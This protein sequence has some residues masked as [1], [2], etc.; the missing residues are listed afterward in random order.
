MSFHRGT[1][2]RQLKTIFMT[3][4]PISLLLVL[5]LVV[6]WPAIVA[7][8]EPAKP[9]RQ[10]E[11]DPAHV[12][13][14]Q[15]GLRLFKTQVRQVLID[16]CVDCHGGSET[17]SGFDLATR[18]GL[19]RGG[20]HGPAIVPGKSADSNV[21]RFISRREK[22]FMPDGAEK[23][24][25]GQI[26]AIAHWIDLGA[27]YDK[28]LVDNPRDPDSWVNTVVPDKARE[29]WSF[30]PLTKVEPP[31]VKHE[32][33]IRN[34]IDRFVLAK[35][36]EKGLMPRAQ[37]D[38]RL[39]LRRAYFDLVGLPPDQNTDA[40]Y[41]ALVDR[42]LESP[43]YGER[44]ARH[45]LD[46][47]RFAESHG[48][49]Q[50]YDRPYAYH[51]RDFVI[52]ALNEDMPYDQFVRWQLAGDEFDPENPLA[53]KATGFLGAGVFPTQIT[54]NEVERTRYDALDDMA[55]TTG[56]AMLGLTIG[57]ARCHDHKFDPIPQADYY[58]LLST[59]TTTVRSNQDVNLDPGPYKIAKAAF[60][61]EHQPLVDALKKFEKD[62][63]PG[64]LAEWETT[65]SA[66]ELRK[67]KWAVLDLAN[68]KSN[69]GATLTAQDDGSIVV[70]G[71]NPDNDTYTFSAT[72]QVETI[73]ALRIE[74]LADDSLPKRGP[75]RGENGNFLLTDLK[76]RA[77]VGNQ[78]PSDVKLAE[79]RATFEQKEMPAAAV[80]D[81]KENTAW[82]IAPQ[83]GKD[84]AIVFQMI[85]PRAAQSN[86]AAD[87]TTKTIVPLTLTFQF[88]FKRSKQHTIGRFRVSVAETDSSSV[89]IG[90]GI[91]E[92]VART[93]AMPA[94]KR[95]DKQSAAIL[96][97]Y[98]HLDPE[99]QK[100][101]AVVAEHAKNEPPAKLV[102]MMVCSEGVTP[103]RHH[104]QGAD[105][106]TETYFLK[107]GDC[108]QKMGVAQQSF[109]Q[110]LM[111]SSDKE[112]RWQV[113]PPEG[114]KSSYRRRSLA[115]WITDTEGGAGH[116]LARVMVNRL[117]HHH[118]GRGVVATPN[119]FGV[120]GA[121]PTHPELLDWLAQELI[122]NEWR[123][124]PIHKLIMTSATY[125]QSSASPP[126]SQPLAASPSAIDPDNALLWRRTP[127][128]LEAEV[129]RDSM[130]AVSGTLDRTLYGPGTL[131]EGHTR[132]SI[133]F[134]VKRSKLV[135]MMQLFDQPEPLVSVGG[136]PSTTI[137]PQALAFLNN[138]QV[139]SYA[140]NFAQRLLPTYDKS[141]ADAVKQGYLT[142]ISREPDADELSQSI[143]FL[144]AQ[145]KSYA[146]TKSENP[147]E[148]ALADFCQ[149]LF[150]LNEF[151][152]VE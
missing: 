68:L 101:H 71:V 3:T 124:K 128:R 114:C 6:L 107:R 50:D 69:G 142:A 111:T 37:A 28:P 27:P 46:A 49:E 35:L 13:K 110:V 136:R 105:F 2:L 54:A 83:I 26:A 108:D 82:G 88:D 122:R 22:P 137:A 131:E 125:R 14:M 94:G 47:A 29:F 134:M 25:A 99:W 11:F 63:L 51:F 42:L 57:C 41:E 73:G 150:G 61:K 18:K 89:E 139:R 34:P 152:Y 33:W 102:K 1:K 106:F 147:R 96:K 93:L 67:N 109:L 97:W 77:K 8:D 80:I 21:V 130:L 23:L 116:L 31:A 70:T 65:A 92:G 60:D 44:W 76:V 123:L 104:T 56:S 24:P 87:A 143:A 135:P 91:P 141:A 133:Y 115:N 16:R 58:R 85:D 81:E 9:D 112:K 84:H 36:E 59:F 132:R 145:E 72:T 39:L 5:P 121:R 53:L 120:Q 74:A 40:N 62:Q 64:R 90:G 55:A 10:A 15:E 118:F 38:D 45:W 48:F 113:T 149:V 103:L 4:T 32:G 126:S 144:A 66:E 20:A 127:H 138:P 43:H 79:A 52:Q 100:L 129:I 95:T 19:V 148:L 151:V 30:Q 98:R 86:E 75:G 117:W 119:D 17:E 7:A 140:H 12:E 146:A 78:N